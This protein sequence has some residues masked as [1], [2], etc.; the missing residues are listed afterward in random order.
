MACA[1]FALLFFPRKCFVVYYAKDEKSV[2]LQRTYSVHCTMYSD[3]WKINIFWNDLNWFDLEECTI[4]AFVMGRHTLSYS[5][6][7]FCPFF[8]RAKACWPLL[9][10]YMAPIFVFL[11]NIWIR[12]Q[13]AAVAS[14]RAT[15]FL[16]SHLHFLTVAAEKVGIFY[17]YKLFLWIACGGG[18]GG[19]RGRGCWAGDLCDLRW[20]GSSRWRHWAAGWPDHSRSHNQGR[21][22]IFYPFYEPCTLLCEKQRGERLKERRRRA[23]FYIFSWDDNG[24]RMGRSGEGRE[25]MA[26]LIRSLSQ[27]SSPPSKKI[28]HAPSQFLSSV[29]KRVIAIFGLMI[30]TTPYAMRWMRAN[31]WRG[32][33]GGGWAQKSLDFQ[34]QCSKLKLQ[35]LLVIN[36]KL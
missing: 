35:N 23:A 29:T 11:T 17:N 1:A 12:T 18:R 14:R 4:K 9:C 19:G 16:A 21:F 36:R 30:Y 3:V 20:R 28:Y 25:A 5:W 7:F 24:S 33:V 8:W 26:S 2:I 27:A 6:F 32:Q 34:G 31:P 10:L 22:I 15:N 13:R